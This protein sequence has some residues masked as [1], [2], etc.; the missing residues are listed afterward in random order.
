MKKIWSVRKHNV[1]EQKAKHIEEKFK[2]SEIVAKVLLEKGIENDN[3]IE[4]FFKPTRNDF[5]DPFEMPDMQKAIDRIVQAITKNE[6]IAIYGD[7]DVDGITST[8]VLKR[9]FK[10]RG[11][12][13][14]SYIPNRLDEGYGMNEEAVHKIADEGYNLIITVDTG[15]TANKEVE[16][17]KKLGIDVIVTD[18]HEPGESIPECVAVVDCK[19]VDSTYPFREL[20]GCGVAFKLT[21]ALS[22][23]LDISE[24]E[25]L[26]YLDLVAVATI[27]DIVPLESENRLIA[28]LGL[29]LLKQTKNEGLRAILK[30][31]NLKKITAESISYIVA[32]RINACGRLGR[33]EVAL[34]LL[35]TDDPIVAR[36]KIEEIEEYNKERQAI[37]QKIYEEALW[38][39]A[40]DPRYEK[41]KAIVVG[42]KNWHAGVI[43]IVSAKITEKYY[44]PSILIGFEDGIGHGSGRSIKGFDLHEAIIKCGKHLMTAGGHEMAIGCK[45]EQD[46]FEKFR[47]EFEAY[48][49]EKITDEMLAE[50]IEIDYEVDDNLFNVKNIED[51]S[52]LEPYGA[53]NKKLL[54]VYKNLKVEAIKKLT[55][56]KHLKLG[57]RS[58]NNY[59]DVIGF[60]MG[61]RADEY[62][63]GDKI[64]VV[65]NLE[66]NEYNG[67]KNA[68]ILLKDLRKSIE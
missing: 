14:G 31:C 15:I 24:N 16:L 41:A 67:R 11:I 2:V 28:Q 43:G 42:K 7:Y 44:K 60:N 5:F 4:K 53:G 54:F 38:E 63:I 65:G 17:A 55:E 46:E 3:E 57:L 30:S 36:K 35:L 39:I 59:I 26:K 61:S 51:L 6:K 18:H 32:P 49:D 9:Y 23:T 56:G 25:C 58:G 20:C 45:I 13:V 48:A 33:Q 52:L 66:I 1:D 29:M 47:D 40:A 34:E 37:E 22:K 68:Q 12:E 27:S 64:D 50:E 19:R 10:D 62:Q 21:Q 8:T